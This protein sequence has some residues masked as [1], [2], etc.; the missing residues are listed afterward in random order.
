[1]RLDDGRNVD[2][3]DAVTVRAAKGLIADVRC[4]A[5]DAPP[6]HGVEPRFDERDPPRLRVIAVH[7]HPVI[8]DVECDIGRV[9]VII[10]E[11]FFY[12]VT[13][14]SERY[15][16]LVDPVRSVELHDVPKQRLA[17]DLDHGLGA[18]AGFFRNAGAAA[19]R[20]DDG[21]HTPGIG[22]PLTET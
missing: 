16:E 6:G 13:F 19:A 3:A 5:L 8:C 9:K 1:M 10:G 22:G 12:Q 17:A 18:D 21:L 15:D 14:V 20:K 2:V 4:A 7:G 11:I